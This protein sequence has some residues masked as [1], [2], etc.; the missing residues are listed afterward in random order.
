MNKYEQ[1]IKLAEAAV[2]IERVKRSLSEDWQQ[3]LQNIIDSIDDIADQ[4]EGGAWN[5]QT[6]ST[7]CRTGWI[8][9]GYV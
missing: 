5:E 1:L 3:P 4:I 6:N 8:S 2:L 7:T 9:T